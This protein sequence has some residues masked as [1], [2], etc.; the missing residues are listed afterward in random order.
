MPQ[1]YLPATHTDADLVLAS[2]IAARIDSAELHVAWSAEHGRVVP[3]VCA[4]L[5]EPA[6]HWTDTV[7][8]VLGVVRELWLALFARDARGTV[9][10]A[11]TAE[12]AADEPQPKPAS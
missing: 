11:P 7:A 6:V 12:P 8:L 2:Q 4:V 9:V 3:E 5:R 1:L 10:S